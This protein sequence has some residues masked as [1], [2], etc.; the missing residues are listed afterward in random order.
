MS[1][2]RSPVPPVEDSL[3]GHGS[4][5]ANDDFAEEA[6]WFARLMLR[7][8]IFAAGAK[9]LSYTSVWLDTARF[10]E[11]VPPAMRSLAWGEALLLIL[12]LIFLCVSW[13]K[14]HWRTSAD[15]KASG[16]G[17]PTQSLLRTFLVIGV[18]LLLSFS[19]F[20]VWCHRQ[21]T[22]YGARIFFAALNIGSYAVFWRCLDTVQWLKLFGKGG[23]LAADSDP[24]RAT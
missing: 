14:Y 18:L 13:V 9:V 21:Q 17:L 22:V 23:R 8:L 1:D 16:P 12:T 11:A 19:C 24:Y 3:S 15:G 6:E 2:M 7:T 4:A 20:G 10:G 5:A